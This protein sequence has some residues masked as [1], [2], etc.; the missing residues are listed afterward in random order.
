MGLGCLLKPTVWA[1]EAVPPLAID[2]YNHG[3]ELFDEATQAAQQGDNARNKSLIQAALKQ[4]QLAHQQ[5]PQ[6]AEAYSNEGYVYLSLKRYRAAQKAFGQALAVN[7][8]HLNSL[9]GLAVAL[10]EACKLPQALA[11]MQTLLTLAPGE[12][13]YQFNYGSLLQRAGQTEA[14]KA[15]YQKTLALEPN[16]QQALFNLA[17][18]YEN[19]HQPTE[20]LIYYRQAKAINISNPIGLEALHRVQALEAPRP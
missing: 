18:L 1:D 11:T 19:A 4:F 8:Q 10:A 3:V 15:A 9:N 17:T 13:Q 12:A 7:P 16:H 20:A 2:T 5:N 14:A 6:L